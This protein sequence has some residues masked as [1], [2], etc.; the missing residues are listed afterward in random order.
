MI[1]VLEDMEEAL[2]TI[3]PKGCRIETDDDGQVVIYTGLTEND[4]GELVPIGSSED[5]EDDEDS[6]HVPYD[7]SD[8][9][10]F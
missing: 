4:E 6:D 3:F 10:D 1:M 9:S 8:D 2:E 7:E 5:E